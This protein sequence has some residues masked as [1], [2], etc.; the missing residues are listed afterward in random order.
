MNAYILIGGRSTRMGKPKP[1]IDLGGVSI[2]ERVAVTAGAVFHAVY[3][4]QTLDGDAAM[5]VPTIREE[6]HKGTAP[7]WGVR[8]ALRHARGRCFVIAVD[9]P[10]LTVELL[11]YL[12]QQFSASA[13]RMLVPVWNGRAQTLCAGYDSQLLPAIDHRIEEGR[14]DLRGLI[15]DAPAV[16]LE[17][18]LLRG[19]FSGEPLLNVNTPEDLERARSLLAPGD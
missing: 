16:L 6:V 12:S 5:V 7:V 17:E 9:Y 1:S 15:D 4:V 13:A 11:S 8:A 18:E 2:L 10:L 14:L 19:R 3:A